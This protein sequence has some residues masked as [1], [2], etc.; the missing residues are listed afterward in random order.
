MKTFLKN[1]VADEAGA[2]AAEYALIIAV[3]GVGIGAAA[4]V[5]GANVKSAVD[6]AAIDVYACA[7]PTTATASKTGSTG[8]EC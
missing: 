1:F 6:N 2:S 3:V 8:D 5:L 7:N 4:L